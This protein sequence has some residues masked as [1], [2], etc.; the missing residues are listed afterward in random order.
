MGND[1]NMGN[2]FLGMIVGVAIMTIIS[3]KII[4]KE[5][6]MSNIKNTR[7]IPASVSMASAQMAELQEEL[8]QAP[9]C[10]DCGFCLVDST[11]A[12]CN[13]GKYKW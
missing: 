9:K 5:K 3:V 1:E 11:Q 8:L 12:T 13:C 2:F 4:L 6:N 10:E 7:G